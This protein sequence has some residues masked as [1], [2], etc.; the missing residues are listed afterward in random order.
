MADISK[1]LIPALDGSPGGIYNIK[2]T[3]ARQMLS[4]GIHLLVVWNGHS[5]PN[6][7][8][9][10]DVVSITYNDVVY[11]GTLAAEDASTMTFYLVYNG[12]GDAN[13]F[14]EYAVATNELGNKYWEKLGDTGGSMSNLGAL[15]YM[16]AIEFNKG[17]GV[18]VIGENATLRASSSEVTFENSDTASVLGANTSFTITDPTYSILPTKGNISLSRATDVSLTTNTNNA[19]TALDSQRS[20]TETFIKADTNAFVK[21]KINSKT[22]RGVT[23]E[24]I[25]ATVTINPVTHK[26]LTS[27]FTPATIGSGRISD[28]QSVEQKYLKTTSIRGVK[29]T[30][31]QTASYISDKTTKTLG[32][33]TFNKV[34]KITANNAANNEWKDTVANLDIHMWSAQTDPSTGVFAEADSETLVLSFKTI[35]SVKVAD[36]PTTFATGKD[37]DNN[38]VS[39]VKDLTIVSV[40]IP[41][42]DDNA[43]TV[44]TG[45]TQTT[46]SGSGSA[47]I[48]SI[49]DNGN[50]PIPVAG[51]NVV[52]ATGK[53]SNSTTTDNAELNGDYV[54]TNVPNGS[55]NVPQIDNSTTEVL[56]KSTVNATSDS[57]DVNVLTGLNF[58][59]KT[60]DAYTGLVFEDASFLNLAS[61]QTQPE[62]NASVVANENGSVL[63]GAS[64]NKITAGGITVGTN[65]LVNAVVDLGTATAAAQ[66]ITFVSKDL[67]KVI[68]Y[69]DLEVNAVD[70]PIEETEEQ[71]EPVDNEIE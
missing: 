46:A 27:S 70:N 28:Y 17:N 21:R 20:T 54:V 13:D 57:A 42:I 7:S 44:A 55:V 18:F 19:L 65:D 10:P 58:A 40:G 12:V 56:I 69:D 1:V 66:E 31:T 5:I 30:A 37:N 11:N 68:L 51:S 47:V 50:I 63:T 32:T 45:E 62:F 6:V 48:T 52:Y 43:T 8:N 33:D 26:L 25:A 41:D 22:M 38:N 67:K 9:I 16:D 49:S 24:N 59:G 23:G 39:F 34:S 29:N 60:A 61:V 53:V 14:A 4:G 3:V 36:S 64:I 35:P 2:D 71:E 15:A